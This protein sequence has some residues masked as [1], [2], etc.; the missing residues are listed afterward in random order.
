MSETH[1]TGDATLDEVLALWR[2]YA[3]VPSTSHTSYIHASRKRVAMVLDAL[4]DSQRERAQMAE[5]LAAAQREV[6]RLREVVVAA[7]QRVIDSHDT[8][9][10]NCGSDAHGDAM[11]FA[12]EMRADGARLCLAAIDAALRVK[13]GA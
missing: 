4:A 3:G 10:A 6:E 13:G 12:D 5:Q 9:A 7:C 11:A 8:A 2:K 1:D